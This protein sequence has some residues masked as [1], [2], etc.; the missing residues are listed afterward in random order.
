MIDTKHML[1]TLK[2]IGGKK[3]QLKYIIP[4]ILENLKKANVYIEPFVGG[5]S[6]II[7]LL[8]QCL[9]ND[10]FDKTFKCYDI[11]EILIE[12]FNEIKDEPEEL[13]RKLKVIEHQNSKEDYLRIRDE[14]NAN[15]TADKFIYLNR[16]GFR[17]LYQVNKNNQFN[18]SF[19]HHKYPKVFRE[20]NIRELSRLFNMF[21]V[22]FEV[23]DYCDIDY[24]NDAVIYLDPPY[25]GVDI[26]YTKDKFNHTK[27]VKYLKKLLEHNCTVIHSNSTMFKD[28]YK[29][30]EHETVE[31]IVLWDRINSKNPGKTRTELLYYT[32]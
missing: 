11:N 4:H 6:V 10:I 13:I 29:M 8:K 12:M 23:A 5:G 2:W 14:Y 30:D 19:G 18:V 28:V 31:E 25:Y 16:M 22:S 7:E 9:K 32:P 26:K 24:D 15:P 20:E 1:P 17:G 21:D 3:E 27:Y